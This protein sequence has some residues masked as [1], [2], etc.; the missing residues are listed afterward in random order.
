MAKIL[1]LSEHVANMIA[2]GEVVESPLSVVK[3]LV[4]NAI[5]AKS[6]AIEINLLESGIQKIEVVDNG[7]GMDAAD[8]MMAFNRHA[9]SKIRNAF[10]IARPLFYILLLVHCLNLLG[11][12]AKHIARTL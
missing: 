11:L 10:D 2:A 3:E 7:S 1:Q 5:D 9:T 6:T 4:E 8:A 12:L